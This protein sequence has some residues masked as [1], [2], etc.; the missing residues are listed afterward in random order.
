MK[1][2]VVGM[3]TVRV[4][5][6]IP[7]SPSAATDTLTVRSAAGA[8]LAVSVNTASPPS[9]TDPAFAATVTTGGGRSSSLTATVPE[10]EAPTV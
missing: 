4:P 5:D 7:N 10:A 8:G 3:V 6:V 1:D 2:P 9:V